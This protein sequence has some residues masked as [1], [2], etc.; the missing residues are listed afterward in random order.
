ML[1][2]ELLELIFAYALVDN[3]PV[4]IVGKHAA[5]HRRNS[6]EKLYALRVSRRLREVASS[7]L[8]RECSLMASI[9][10]FDFRPLRNWLYGIGSLNMRFLASNKHLGIVLRQRY[11]ES[12]SK[13]DHRELA[14]WANW[15]TNPTRK[16][17][18]WTYNIL[19]D[20]GSN[21]TLF[22][23]ELREKQSWLQRALR[24]LRTEPLLLTADQWEIAKI[25]DL[26]RKRLSELKKADQ[27]SR[28]FLRDYE[29]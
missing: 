3:I 29:W 2:T 11:G 7:V 13:L 26:F 21:E 16:R 12:T 24:R 20:F 25:T 18:C 14:W 23:S 9:H 15:A 8:Y 19:Y 27:N 1:P 28:D 6:K 22:T 5:F 10:G 17:I 4:T